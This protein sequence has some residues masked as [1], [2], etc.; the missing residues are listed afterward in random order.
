[1]QISTLPPPHAYAPPLQLP[2]A[3][4]LRILLRILECT[5]LAHYPMHPRMPYT[6][7]H[8]PMRHLWVTP[9]RQPIVPAQVP[10]SP[11]AV[12]RASAEG[13]AV[14]SAV[15]IVRECRSPCAAPPAASRS[16]PA[17]PSALRGRYRHPQCGICSPAIVLPPGRCASPNYARVRLPRP[18]RAG[19]KQDPSP[20]ARPIT[21]E[22]LRAVQRTP[23]LP[24]AY[25]KGRCE[26]RCAL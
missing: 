12:I 25:G 7:P 6:L 1:M 20:A 2:D 17:G 22:H 15:R 9:S 8:Y 23:A 11:L 24:A 5:T 18:T 21:A 16:R 26:L 13:P 14:R 3:S 19:K 4:M 10:S